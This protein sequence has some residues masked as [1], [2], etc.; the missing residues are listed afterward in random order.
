MS[1]EEKRPGAAAG[2]APL[3][4]EE[5]L[6]LIE[7][8]SRDADREL[9]LD[10]TPIFLLWGVAFLL[11]W[12]AFYCATTAGPGPFLPLWGAGVILGVLYAAAIALPIVI[13]VRAGRGVSGPSRVTGAMY[14][15]SWF[16]GFAALAAINAGVVRTGLD[17]AA[18]S[19][20]WSGSSMLIVGLL[21]LAGGMVWTDRVQYALGVWMLVTGAGSVFA[22]YPGNLLVLALA[23]GGGFLVQAGYYGLAA[24]VGRR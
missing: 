17:T 13:S 5:S 2:E 10:P 14:G 7:S 24:R 21:Y 18:V 23:G 8:Q 4:P 22:G 3:S 15:W 16:L 19:L 6:A 12:G 20:L 1:S 11:G 9:G